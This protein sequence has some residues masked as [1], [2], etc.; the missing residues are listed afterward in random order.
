MVA[1]PVSPYLTPALVYFGRVSDD[2]WDTEQDQG[3][4]RVIIEET[5]GNGRAAQLWEI[6][7]VVTYPDREQARQAA[8][9]LTESHQPIHPRSPQG[10]CSYQLGPDGWLVRV[11]GA[12]RNFHF[13]VYVA[14]H[15]GGPEG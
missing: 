13:R 5:V 7:R 4:W 12:M 15:V 3:G 1:T 2:G 10:R 8:A 6:T 14:R 9:V 11:F